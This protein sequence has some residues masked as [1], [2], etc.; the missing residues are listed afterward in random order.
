MVYWDCPTF[1]NEYLPAKYSIDWNSAKTDLGVNVGR[2]AGMV[3][4]R[5]EELDEALEAY[6][7]DSQLRAE[8]RK[9][10]RAQ[11]LFNPGRATTAMVDRLHLLLG[12]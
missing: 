11:L 1:F 8:Q 12:A 5:I 3:V 2:D 7:R 4:S 10:V 9:E 6:R